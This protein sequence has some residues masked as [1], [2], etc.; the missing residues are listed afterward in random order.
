MSVSMTDIARQIGKPQSP[1]KSMLL[2]FNVYKQKKNKKI[3]KKDKIEGKWKENAKK[4]RKCKGKNG[5]I[6]R[7]ERKKLGS[8]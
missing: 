7:K 2:L 1:L 5:N 8:H 4:D 6:F 3:K